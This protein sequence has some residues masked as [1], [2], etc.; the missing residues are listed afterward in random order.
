MAV[1]PFYGASHPELFGIERAAMDRPGRVIAH[2]DARL[3]ER[4]LVVDIGA[5]DGHTAEL[6]QRS[7]R[8]VVPVEPSVEM[9]HSR[10]RDTLSW[11]R[12][13]AA[14]L[15]FGSGAFQGAY[16]TWAYF[17]SRD[18][19]PTPGLNELH[20]IVEPG[21]PLLIVDN[22]GSDEF[23]ALASTDITADPG[24]WADR[25]F[26]CQAIDTF[27]EFETLDDARRLLGLYFGDAGTAGAATRLSYRVG[28]FHGRSHGPT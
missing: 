7:E 24:Y 2:L 6:L 23:T 15:P 3:P 22:L 12:G 10:G 13:D 16:A 5:G 17:F 9:I 14:R 28:L 18:W 11:V 20:R 25:G 27:F 8:H 19:D 4:G 1:I 21:G 26:G